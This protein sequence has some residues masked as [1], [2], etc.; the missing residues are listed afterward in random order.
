MY[1]NNEV[2]EEELQNCLKKIKKFSQ[3]KGFDFIYKELLNLRDNEQF[4]GLGRVPKAGCNQEGSK[5]KFEE[6]KIPFIKAAKDG[7]SNFPLLYL[8]P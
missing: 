8:P 6:D 7:T 5:W 2:Y 1:D 4:I 3:I